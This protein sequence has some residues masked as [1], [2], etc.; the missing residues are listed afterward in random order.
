MR[1][2]ALARVSTAALLIC[3]TV[4]AIGLLGFGAMVTTN[5]APWFSYQINID[6]AADLEIH[7]GSAC[8]REV[9]V[10][11]CRWSGM[12][13]RREFRIVYRANGFRHP[14]L[15]IRLPDR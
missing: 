12:V 8:P 3:V 2:A 9:P 1:P 11:V 15:S 10:P 6:G 4:L 13:H 5:T 7:N 14:V